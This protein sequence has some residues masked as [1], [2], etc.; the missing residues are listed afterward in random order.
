MMTGIGE[1][2]PPVLFYDI[3]GLLPGPTSPVDLEGRS[4][5]HRQ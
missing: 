1:N 5:F 2:L 3:A 4:I